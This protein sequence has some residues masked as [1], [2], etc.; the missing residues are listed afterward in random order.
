M[1]IIISGDTEQLVSP[2]PEIY[3]EGRNA[4]EDEF[5]ILACDGIWDVMTNE[6]LCQF[7]SHQMAIT[8]DLTKVAASVVDYCLFKVKQQSSFVF[9]FFF[10]WS[11]RTLIW[12]L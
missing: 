11:S 7:V 6:D 4:E 8:D 9:T 12:K 10:F 2:E 3:V 1:V 5:I